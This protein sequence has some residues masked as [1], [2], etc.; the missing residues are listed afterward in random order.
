MALLMP[1]TRAWRSARAPPEF[2]GLMGASV[3]IMVRGTPSEPTTVRATLLTTPEVT[4][5]SRP[6]GL[7]MAMA[8]WPTRMSAVVAAAGRPLS[9]TRTTATSLLASAPT[10]V[11]SRR[12]PS[13]RRTVTS[14]LP[15]T[16]WAAVRM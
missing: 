7:P 6:Q 4:V 8:I 2:P 16:T 10:R 15:A 11:P 9:S 12:V 13:A 14:R 3:W 5:W 1:I